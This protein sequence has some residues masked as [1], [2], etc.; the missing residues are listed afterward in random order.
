MQ[1]KHLAEALVFEPDPAIDDCQGVHYSL[2]TRHSLMYSSL[3]RTN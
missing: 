3:I 1:L 2:L